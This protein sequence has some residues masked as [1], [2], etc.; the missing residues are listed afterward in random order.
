MKLRQKTLIIL[1]LTAFSLI[2]VQIAIAVQMTQNFTKFEESYVEREVRKVLNIV[3]N[4]MSS[5]S[6]T[7][8]DW[9]YWDDTYK[10]MQDQNQ[11]YIKSNLGDT[12]VDNLRLNLMLYVNLQGQIVYS[13][14]YDLKNKTSLPSQRA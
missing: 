8:Q 2:I 6:I 13:K 10:F 1:L 11:E 9:A 12:S 5:L 4:E 14:Y 7:P 3:D